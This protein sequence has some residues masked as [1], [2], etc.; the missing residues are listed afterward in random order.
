LDESGIGIHVLAIGVDIGGTKIAG[1][2]VAHDGRILA[3]E[4]VDTPADEPELIL[5]LVTSM[6][7]RLRSGQL[8]AGVGVVVPGFIDRTGDTV[9]Y[10]PNVDWR[11]EPLKSRL[12]QRIDVPVT[13]DNDANAA[14]WAEFIYG[15][16]RMVSDMTMLT[17][18]TGVGGA[19][20]TGGALFRGGFGA[21]AELGHMRLV[22]NGLPCGCGAR[23]CVEQYGSGRALQRFAERIA[24]NDPVDGVM[25]A[26]IRARD[27]RLT[28]EAIG[29]LIAAGDR[30]AVTALREIGGWIGQAAASLGAVLDPEMFVIGGGVALAGDLLLD[31][32][33]D[34]YHAHLPARGF[35]PEAS[36]RTAELGNDAGMVGAAA[37]ARDA[38]GAAPVVPVR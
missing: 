15:A 2:L 29:E 28:G 5:D 4:R 14:G 27:G 22:P 10:A 1:A 36:F 38:A 32:I 24:D 19:V 18:G 6:V 17:I 34:S 26:A 33:R 25:L 21:G 16:G 13:V 8:I 11:D 9:Y 3:E 37:L 23:G 30:G 7:S 31:P 20:I 12:Q 35:H